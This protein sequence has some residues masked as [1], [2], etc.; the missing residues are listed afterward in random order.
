MAA[1][2]RIV[3]EKFVS[4]WPQIT[5]SVRYRSSRKLFLKRLWGRI[6]TN[7]RIVFENIVGV[8]GHECTDCF[9]KVCEDVTANYFVCSLSLESQIYFEKIVG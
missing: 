5:S 1:N 7:A 6:A 9:W 2:A 8:N 4:R 3:F